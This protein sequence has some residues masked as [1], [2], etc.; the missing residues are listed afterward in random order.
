MI[1]F[2]PGCCQVVATHADQT[3]WWVEGKTDTDTRQAIITTLKAFYGN[4]DILVLSGV[5]FLETISI[6]ILCYCTK[7]DQ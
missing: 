7:M 3:H 4:C 2:I 5:C 1:S 6:A